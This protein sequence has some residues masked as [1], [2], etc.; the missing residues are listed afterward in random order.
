ML[1]NVVTFRVIK[2][3]LLKINKNK[4]CKMGINNLN[5]FLR[6][7]CPEVFVEKDLSEY[8]YKKVAIDISLYLCK[9]KAV[10]G[11]KWISA[12]INLI[13][14]LRKNDIHCI[15]IYDN[16]YPEEKIKERKER[17][18]QRKKQEENIIELEKSISNYYENYEI[19]D[20]LKQI[21][22]KYKDKEQKK[23]L[24][25][26]RKNKFDIKVVENRLEKM[27]S[28]MIKINKN[29]FEL[30]K[31]LFEILDVPYHNAILEAE[32][33]CSDLCK[34]GIVD[35]VLSEDTDVLAYNAPIF[36]TKIDTVSNKCIEIQLDKVLEKL[37]LNKDEFL[38]FCILLGTDYNK[39]IP[40]YGPVKS[41]KL[42][43]E[44][45][46]I[47]NI[48]SLGLNTD[49]LNYKRVRELFRD[50]ESLKIDKIKYCGFPNSEK[51]HYFIF[52]NNIRYSAE[53]LISYFENNDI[54]IEDDE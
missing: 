13:C 20:L 33:I 19:D 2:I 16:G 6:K 21:Y 7:K 44:N 11:D 30:T 41:Y 54:I 32:T 24:L 51:L 42:I 14:C 27:K 29:D 25:I 52:K 10:C 34:K 1:K 39:N 31:E 8:A 47:E 38:D 53:Y 4:K 45:R 35:C 50:Y 48:E 22:E 3:D 37:E 36:L 46:K 9:F 43:C 12:F 26:K 28:N 17:E 5:K 40:R 49:I 23:R 18:N 15:F